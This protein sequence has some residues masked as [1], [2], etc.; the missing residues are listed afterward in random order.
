MNQDSIPLDEARRQ[1][2]LVCRRLGLLHL[3]FADVLVD[4]LGA[5][6]GKR[7]L[8]RAIKEYLAG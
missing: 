2:A 6:R 5:D 4:Q 1:V 3:A 7:V 8:A